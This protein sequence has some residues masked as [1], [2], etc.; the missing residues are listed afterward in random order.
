MQQVAK[1]NRTWNLVP[2]LQIVQTIPDNYYPCLH[3]SIGQVWW[4]NKLWFKRHFQ[5]CTLSDALILIMTS[6]IWQIIAWLKTQKHEYLENITFLWNKKFLTCIS[7]DTFW[8][9]TFCSEG[10]LQ[11]IFIYPSNISISMNRSN[12]IFT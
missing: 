1:L 4:L 7:D 8:E 9:V 11:M 10:N 12:Y 6:Q 3:L 5:K 2:V